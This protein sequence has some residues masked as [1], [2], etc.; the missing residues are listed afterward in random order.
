MFFKIN[1]LLDENT[2]KHGRFGDIFLPSKISHKKYINKIIYFTTQNI[3]IYKNMI[4]SL[5]IIN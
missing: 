1:M 2:K 3:R 5:N 4:E